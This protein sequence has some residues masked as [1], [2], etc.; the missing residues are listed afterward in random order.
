MSAPP[1]ENQ[2]TSKSQNKT[3]KCPV[4]ENLFKVKNIYSRQRLLRFIELSFCRFLH[5]AYLQHGS[6]L[7]NWD[8]SNKI[9][10][11]I[12]L[13]T[14]NA[15][16]KIQKLY[17][18][19]FCNFDWNMRRTHEKDLPRIRRAIKSTNQ[20]FLSWLLC[21]EVPGWDGALKSHE[22][23]YFYELEKEDR[24]E[25]S[26]KI[27]IKSLKIMMQYKSKENMDYLRL[28]SRYCDSYLTPWSS[29]YIFVQ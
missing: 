6:E 12:I 2:V 9:F 26:L 8:K 27:M 23:K 11:Q 22:I 17:F 20:N 24:N 7:R 13:V 10:R 14:S 1:L 5:T 28:F 29:L 18:Y 21:N 16:E 4:C 19:F 25:K 3:K 15:A